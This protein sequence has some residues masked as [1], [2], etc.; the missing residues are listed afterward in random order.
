VP[1]PDPAARRDK[2]IVLTG[3]VPS[4]MNPPPGCYFHT[5]CPLAEDRCRVERPLAREV[6]P[7]HSVTCHLR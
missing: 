3:D 5:R 2:R 4:P 1:V 7:G 6:T